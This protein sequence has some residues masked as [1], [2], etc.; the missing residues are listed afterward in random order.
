MLPACDKVIC[1]TF[2]KMLLSIQEGL[3]IDATTTTL[4]ADQ[5]FRP[6]IEDVVERQRYLER[7]KLTN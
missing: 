5:T 1:G 7:I 6:M 4:R 2:S 3:T